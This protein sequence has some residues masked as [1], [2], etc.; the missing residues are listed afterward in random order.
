MV[1]RKKLF[2]AHF[3]VLV[4]R[5]PSLSFIRDDVFAQ[6]SL[7]HS[8]C[9]QSFLCQAKPRGAL[10]IKYASPSMIIKSALLHLLML[11]NALTSVVFPTLADEQQMREGDAL[12]T[13]KNTFFH[14]EIY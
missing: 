13:L 6:Q 7:Y 2:S 1:S 4:V 14:L 12:R 8:L 11:N 10:Q 3:L 5:L 9:L